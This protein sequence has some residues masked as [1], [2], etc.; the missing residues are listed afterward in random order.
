MRIQDSVGLLPFLFCFPSANESP[1]E[2]TLNSYLPIPKLLCFGRF[3]N[4]TLH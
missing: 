3:S 4:E 2:S 1:N